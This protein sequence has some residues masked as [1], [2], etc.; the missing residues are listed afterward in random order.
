MSL[1]STGLVRRLSLAVFL[2]FLI[3]SVG[4]VLARRN[5][6]LN[7]FTD[8]WW[9]VAV[10]DEYAATGIFA[11]DPFFEDAPPFAQFGLMDYLNAHI[12]SSTRMDTR[13]TFSL[14]ISGQVA[15]FLTGAFLAGYWP[16]RQMLCGLVS[17]VG[18]TLTFPGHTLIVLGF[19]FAAA[20]A[21]LAFVIVSLVAEPGNLRPPG[22]LWRGALLGL[23][24]S[25]HAFVGLVGVLVS[26]MIFGFEACR[27]WH[28][29]RVLRTRVLAWGGFFAAF[30][31]V[32]GRWWLHHLSLRSALSQVNAHM[33]D[34][35]PVDRGPVLLLLGALFLVG[36]VGASRDAT[37][38]ARRVALGLVVFGGFLGVCCLPPINALVREHISW[39]MARRL[40]WLF[41]TG[42]ALALGVS[43]LLD[44]PFMSGPRK[45][46]SVA[47]M[48]V[49]CAMV[50]PAAKVWG[51]Q[52]LYLGRTADYDKHDFEYIDEWAA[53]GGT[54]RGQTVLSDRTTSY[55]VRGMLKAY[56]CAMIPGEGSPAIDY[57]ARNA[58]ARQA[59]VGGPDQLMGMDV[60]AVLLD[61][62]NG[63][64]ERFTGHEVDDLVTVWTRSGWRVEYDM[65]HFVTL[66]P[67][68]R[69]VQA[70]SPKSS[71][72]P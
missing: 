48:L 20:T 65:P 47:V 11:R 22:F 68:P 42:A 12:S 18:W 57:A 59:L 72:T 51:L 6:V 49:M 44:K 36:L 9:H 33:R 35:Y 15:L 30:L 66:M 56:V 45:A 3:G 10:A 67:G 21:V 25:L 52:Q 46:R 43:M 63:A 17:A 8:S 71:P 1:L 26:I 2:I 61:R 27:R 62:K 7:R 34:A 58:F 31:L 40:P 55:Y 5:V 23:V 53:P 54:W 37:R 29:E 24:F 16:G 32:S 13:Q 19:P 38:E 39:Y 28:P 41:P 70:L 50:I 64:T 69:P 60:D 4:F 14:L